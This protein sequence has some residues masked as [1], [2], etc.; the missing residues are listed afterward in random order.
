[1]ATGVYLALEFAPTFG[2]GMEQ[3]LSCHQ[4]AFAFFGGVP[5]KIGLFPAPGP[6]FPNPN[7]IPP[8]SPKG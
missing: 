1:V 8:Q 2:Q 3:F 4:N 6:T 7:G 5:E